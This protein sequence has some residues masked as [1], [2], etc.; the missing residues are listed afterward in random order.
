MPFFVK[1]AEQDAAI[2]QFLQHFSS[3]QGQDYN[4]V[5]QIY[6]RNQRPKRS[7]PTP[8]QSGLTTPQEP[9]D[10]RMGGEERQIDPASAPPS[11]MQPFSLQGDAALSVTIGALGVNINEQAAVTQWCQTTPQNNLEVFNMVKAYHEKVI[12]PEYYVLVCQLEAG[13]KTISD[14]VFKVQADL[15]W[16]TAE[17][18]L[19]QKYACGLQLLTTGWP[20]ALVPDDRLYT[21]SW[22]IMQVPK[23]KQF[24]EIRGFV[25]DQTAHETHRYLNILQVEP[26]TVP[27]REGFYSGMT[28]LSFK[29][30]ECR[31]AFL[32]AYGGA[33]GVPV[34]RDE[35]TPV[36]NH[37]VRVAPCSP[38]WQ[39]KME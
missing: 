34:Y 39:R 21:I 3:F 1:M 33:N 9:E 10:V 26:T 4:A 23:L 38:Q 2:Q 28:M 7:A 13:L 30:W 35:S 31:Q 12:R 8:V 22:M 6:W 20:N 5:Q 27:Q 14:Q 24:L 18:R 32:E 25:S 17:N 16:M 29:S 36:H 19:S 37:H 15:A 11:L